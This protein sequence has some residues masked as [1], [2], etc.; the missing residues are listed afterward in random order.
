M[1]RIILQPDPGA[2]V[3]ARVIKVSVP[4]GPGD[5]RNFYRVR[6]A[7]EARQPCSDLRWFI[8]VRSVSQVFTRTDQDVDIL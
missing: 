5:S 1:D 8:V 7:I 4:G 6:K 3:I 2:S